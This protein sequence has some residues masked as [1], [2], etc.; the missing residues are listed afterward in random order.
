MVRISKSHRKRN[1]IPVF[2]SCWFCAVLL[3]VIGITGTITM[4]LGGIS[5]N[6]SLMVGLLPVADAMSASKILESGK[7]Y[8]IYGTAWKKDQTARLVQEAIRSG[9][10]F[11]DT[12]CQPKHYNE[13]GVGQG[14]VEAIKELNLS[15]SDLFLQTKFTPMDGQDPE[16]LPYDRD[17]SLEDQVLE[18]IDTSLRNLRTTYIDSL[19]LHS[20]LRSHDLT[21]RVWRVLEQKVE[22]GVI[23]QL[24]ISN[25]YN[26]H[27]FQMLYD[28]ARIKPAVLQN[29]FYSDSGFDVELRAF[30]ADHGIRYQS[31]WTLTSR[32]TRRNLQRPEVQS[33]AHEKGLSPATLMYAYMMELGHT[34]LSGTTNKEHML[35]DVAVM[36]RIQGGEK[37]LNQQE[38][39]LLTDWL[40]IEA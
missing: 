25:C 31:F 21:M 15:R 39:D 33:M 4:K 38:L 24:G 1:R 28:D 37:L 20:P 5:N 18:S 10:R 17:A 36:E 8:I 7:P 13:D 32:T 12:A 14:I 23:R 26:L 40:G 30:C 9:F 3:T 6:Y 2:K 27:H 16:R 22:D 19:V 34:P 11:I 29:R 35:A